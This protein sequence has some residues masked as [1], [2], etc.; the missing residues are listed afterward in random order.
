MKCAVI[1]PVGPG[2]EELYCQCR[3]SIQAA[4][5]QDKG[6]F[7]EIVLLPVD[8]LEGKQ[9]RSTA[10]NMGVK[11]AVEKGIDWIFFLDADDV[12]LADAFSVITPY[13]AAYDAVWG[14][15][16][17]IEAGKENA[18]LRIP[19][20]LTIDNLREL[21]VFDPFYTIQMGHFV[22][23]SVALQNPFEESLDCGEDFQY[24]L[25]VWSSYRCRKIQNP[26]FVNRRGQHSRGAR[27]ATGQQWR[28]AVER[29]L[30]HY[31]KEAGI[32][33][34]DRELDDIARAKSLEYSVFSRQEII[35]KNNMF[36]KL[37]KIYN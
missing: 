3:K 26:F 35:A 37:I 34:D 7:E 16:A 24:Y 28:M 10:R 21:L 23:S 6:P 27:S 8:D 30:A 13:L 22:R 5:A 9:G 32:K 19:Q 4:M 15:I 12:L 31:Q 17:E 2:H 18:V 25:K 20:V 36:R 11:M 14:N 1:T 29:L 33:I